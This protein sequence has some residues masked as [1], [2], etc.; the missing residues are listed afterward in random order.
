MKFVYNCK[1]IKKKDQCDDGE[2]IIV[3][4]TWVLFKEG[5][6]GPFSLS[7]WQNKGSEALKKV[8]SSKASEL[9]IFLPS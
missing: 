2:G 4:N 1:E 7:Q 6:D 8:Y 9:R 5:L 3:I